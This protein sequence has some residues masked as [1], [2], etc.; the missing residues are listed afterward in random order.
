M[1]C[2]YSVRFFH[3][4]LSDILWN[5]YRAVFFPPMNSTKEYLRHLLSRD[6][7]RYYFVRI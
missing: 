5:A 7:Y 4:F 6:F 1:S 2:L 3:S